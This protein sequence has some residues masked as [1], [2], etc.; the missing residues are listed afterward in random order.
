MNIRLLY[1]TAETYPTFRADVRVLFGKVLP[2]HGIHSDIVAGKTPGVTGDSSVW[3]GGESNLCDV[4]GGPISKHF[5]TFFHGIRCMLEADRK[6]YHAIQVR[7][8][9]IAAAIGLLIARFKGLRFYYWMS[10]PMPEGQI[11]LARE[12]GLS[13]GLMKFIFPWLN[14]RIGRLLLYRVVLP[15]VNHVFVQSNQMKIDLIKLGIRSEIMTSVPMGVDLEELQNLDIS[16][17]NDIHLAGKRVLVY[18]GTLIRPRKIETLFEMLAIVKREFPNVLLVLVGDAQDEPHQRWLEVKAEEAGVKDQLLW[19]GWLSMFEGWRYVCAAEVGLS[20]FPRGYLL[21]S[22]SPTK[23]P[24]Y[25]ALGVPVVC[26]ENPDQEQVI[27]QSGAGVCAPYTALDFANAVIQLLKMDKCKR[28][29]MV[30]KGK[31]Y[32]SKCRDYRIIG[33]NLAHSYRDLLLKEGY[34]HD[35]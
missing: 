24:E 27:L 29:E 1:L 16:P 12:R 30:I 21:D 26:N 33:S 22:A 17:M 2:Q 4:S 8:M 15:N 34:G 18:L 6:R 14:G 5:K 32:I 19:T 10:Y 23:V 3:D 35:N 28:N 13:T 11:L 9:P 7:D 25:L 31:S 20:P